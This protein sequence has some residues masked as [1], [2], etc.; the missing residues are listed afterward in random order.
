MIARYLEWLFLPP[1][2]FVLLGLLGLMLWRRRA[3]RLLIAASVLAL[4]AL[5]TPVTAFP[6]IWYSQWEPALTPA[7][8]AGVDAQ[9]I[10]ILGGG[11]SLETPNY[12]H[13]VDHWT[14]GRLRF[15]ALLHRA[16][17]LPV[18]VTGGLGDKYGPAVGTMMKEV[19]E[20]EFQVPV[21]LAETQ[22]RTT[23]E[24]A[25]F[26]WQLLEPRGIRRVLLVTQ[27]FHMP[28]SVEAFEKAGF[29]VIAAP[30]DYVTGAGGSYAWWPQAR[31]LYDSS[32]VLHELVGR[33][34]YRLRY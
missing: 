34:W 22:S 1:G 27:A 14:L 23:H 2:G 24:N 10:V 13:T 25:V 30:T 8:A 5:A 26:T 6:M 16:T 20:T 4:W 28:R 31:T 15:G 9:A 18:V 3:G 7:Q 17:G 32:M 11:R 33:V 19:L 29:E 21:L 12:N